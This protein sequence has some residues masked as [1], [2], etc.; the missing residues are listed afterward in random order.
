MEGGNALALDQTQV[1][2]AAKVEEVEP[3]TLMTDTPAPDKS[4]T[5][6]EPLKVGDKVWWD[7]CPGHC[8]WTNPFTITRI[9]SA[10]AWL[11]IYSKPVPV[12]ELKRLQ[13]WH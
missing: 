12:L 8:S 1:T 6:N 5:P 2:A 9:Y 3:A 11:D 4:P 13:E 10:M 7:N